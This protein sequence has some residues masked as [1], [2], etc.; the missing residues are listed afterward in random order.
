MYK[1]EAI[2]IIVH[3][4]ELYRENLENR[5]ILILSSDKHGYIH[6]IEVEFAPRCFMHLTGVVENR[7]YVSSSV[8]FYDLCLRNKL[9]E[10]FFS[11]APDG[12]T[13]LKLQVLPDLLK[14]HL[15][16][17]S[18]G[19]FNEYTPKLYTEKIAGS[20]YACMGFVKS[21][22]FYYPNTILRKDIRDACERPQQRIIMTCRKR[23]GE[24]AYCDRVY[25][26]KKI[27]DWGAF[28]VDDGIRAKIHDGI[29]PF[30]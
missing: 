27:S 9:G 3:C 25:L 28:R 18:I 10:V 26:A 4:A 17:N 11:M 29:Y 8:Q 22:G 20:I 2:G 15:S 30:N 19:N 16:A 1:R 5:N 12:T 21:N 7:K 13:P 14:P 24:A 23:V 6:E